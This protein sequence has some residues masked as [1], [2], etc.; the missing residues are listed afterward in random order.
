MTGSLSLWRFAEDLDQAVCDNPVLTILYLPDSKAKAVRVT[1]M[2]AMATI[3]VSFGMRIR[4]AAPHP[5]CTSPHAADSE[6][7]CVGQ[8]LHDL[9]SSDLQFGWVDLPAI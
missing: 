2:A 1:Y 3:M 5:A 6:R 4:I 9:R 8:L 7:T